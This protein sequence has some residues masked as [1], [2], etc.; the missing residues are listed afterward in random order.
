MEHKVLLFLSVLFI[1]TPLQAQSLRMGADDATKVYYPVIRKI[2]QEADIDSELNVMPGGRSIS[3]ANSGELDGEIWRIK[4]IQNE[5]S[6]LIPVPTPIYFIKFW[7]Y[8]L[9]DGTV[10]QKEE[11]LRGKT[12]GVMRGAVVTEN[13]LKNLDAEIIRA[14]NP[15]IMVELLE[16]RRVDIVLGTW[17]FPNRMNQAGNVGKLEAPVITEPIYIWLHKKH[18]DLIPAIDA[19]IRDWGIERIHR[20][21]DSL[22]D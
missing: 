16:R 10:I 14:K 20:E 9:N 8:Y 12:I 3:I 2:L 17:R 18:R 4:A 11:D 6:N 19:V 15:A 21:I 13:Y 7:A 22:P 1:S 5:N